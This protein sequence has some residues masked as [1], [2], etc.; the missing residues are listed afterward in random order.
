M[1]MS[2]R[3]LPTSHTIIVVVASAPVIDVVVGVS[4]VVLGEASSGVVGG[5]I[6]VGLEA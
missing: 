5:D 2:F 1:S 3:R 4:D 6:E